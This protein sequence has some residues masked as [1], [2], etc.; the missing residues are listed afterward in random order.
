MKYRYFLTYTPPRFHIRAVITHSR[1][2]VQVG[3]KKPSQ[4]IQ[5]RRSLTKYPGKG[6]WVYYLKWTKTNE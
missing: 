5:S 1:L 3:S 6:G 4:K 2:L